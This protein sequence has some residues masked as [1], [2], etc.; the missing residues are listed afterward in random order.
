MPSQYERRESKKAELCR[1][2]DND[3][4]SC[5]NCKF[6]KRQTKTSFY[7]FNHSIRVRTIDVCDM[8]AEKP[9]PVLK[10]TLA[11]V[12]MQARKAPNFR[13]AYLSALKAEAYRV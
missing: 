5:K 10:P 6:F 9:K 3:E 4:V 12:R 2:S 13:E 7:C 11:E 8:F 1:Q